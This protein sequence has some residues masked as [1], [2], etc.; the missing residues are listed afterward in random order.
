MYCVTKFAVTAL[1]EGFRA[2]LRAIQSNIKVTVSI[3]L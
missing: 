2:E 3:L 1:T